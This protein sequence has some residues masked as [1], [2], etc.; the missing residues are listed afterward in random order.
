MPHKMQA[1]CIIAQSRSTWADHQSGVMASL[2]HPAPHGIAPAPHQISQRP[3]KNLTRAKSALA[4]VT[5]AKLRASMPMLNAKRFMPTPSVTI[6]A[7]ESPY[8]MKQPFYSTWSID[9]SI[10]EALS[11]SLAETLG[12][13]LE[14]VRELDFLQQE[15]WAA[16][17]LWGERLEPNE[18]IS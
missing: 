16:A 18:T 1:P 13:Q 12:D 4:G 11:H 15:D 7:K 10:D 6:P 14:Q 3:S 9:Q 5:A 8:K 2:V 17:I